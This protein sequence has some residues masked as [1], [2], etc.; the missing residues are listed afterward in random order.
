MSFH[1]NNYRIKSKND[2][3]I[4]EQLLI[5][6]SGNTNISLL[7]GSIKRG[8]IEMNIKPTQQLAHC[9]HLEYNEK[10]SMN[11]LLKRGQGTID[12]LNTI[13]S[14]AKNSYYPK[15]L[16]SIT[17][18]DDSYIY[19]NFGKKVYLYWAYYL[20]NGKTWYET[21]FNAIPYT[22]AET[23]LYLENKTKL[24]MPINMEW[25]LFTSYLGPY[26]NEIKLSMIKNIFENEKEKGSSW[27]TL[28]NQLGQDVIY[29]YLGHNLNALAIKLDLFMSK[30]WIIH[31]DN[32]L[33]TPYEQIR[34]TDDFLNSIQGRIAQMKCGYRVARQETI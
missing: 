7:I 22:N 18:E 14:F 17:L 29:N 23:N 16:Q 30:N 2:F 6:F 34:I 10:C 13:F 24:N 12:M 3:F 15:E 11:G 21:H 25:Q 19:N 20:T 28:F 27:Q 5:D 8:C 26:T 32:Y 31:L 1:Q 4:K 33:A 9:S